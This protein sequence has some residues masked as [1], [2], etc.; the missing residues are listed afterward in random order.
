MSPI[1]QQQ[2][3]LSISVWLTGYDEVQLQGTGMQ[4]TYFATITQESTA[5]NLQLFLAEAAFILASGEGDEAKTN[6]LIAD[7]LMPSSSYDNLAQ[8]IIYMWYSGQWEPTVSASNA[9]LQEV[10]NISPNA[11]IQGLMWDAAQTHPP[12]A[13][14]PGY[15][16][17]ATLPLRE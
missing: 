16:S 11:Y 1:Q 15:G 4:E 10:R 17:W 8:N 5:E 12:G 3:F 9:N 7:R 13:K 6:A 2:V 14:Q